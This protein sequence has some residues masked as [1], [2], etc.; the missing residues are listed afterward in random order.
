MRHGDADAV[1]IA[2][3]KSNAALEDIAAP[4]I[5]QIGRTGNGD[6]AAKQGFRLVLLQPFPPGHAIHVDDEGLD[7]I[8]AGQQITLRLIIRRCNVHGQAIWPRT[9]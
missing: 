5:Q 1:R 9:V 4:D 8:A 6:A 7:Q 2:G 3:I